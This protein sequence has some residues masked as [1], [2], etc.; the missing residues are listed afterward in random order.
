M[1]PIMDAT[2]CRYVGETLASPTRVQLCGRIAVTI[3]GERLDERLPGRQGRLLFVFLASN[4]TRR[5]HRDE[6]AGALWPEEP[7]S[8]PDT[9]LSAVLSKLRRV[10]GEHRLEGRNDVRLVLPDEAWVDLEVAAEGIHRAEAAVARGEWTAAWGPARVAQHVAARGFLPGE[11]APW[12]EEQRRQLE[13]IYVR[14]LELVARACLGIGGAELDTAERAARRLV[15]AA[16]YRESGYRLL[17]Q[18]LAARGNAAEALLVYDSLRCRLRDELGTAPSPETQ[19]L[20]GSL[21][22]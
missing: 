2:P 22:A 7:P 11:S 4:R 10:L 15:A 9:A 14:S 21:L 17:M 19:S 1:Q 20:H 16:P 5:V 8:A 12:I 3:E 18:I 13:T 6:L